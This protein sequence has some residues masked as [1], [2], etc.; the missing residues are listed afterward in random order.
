MT[1]NSMRCMKYILIVLAL[2]GC[3][4]DDAYEIP[5]DAAYEARYSPSEDVQIVGVLIPCHPFLAEY[6]R[7]VIMRLRGRTHRCDLGV[8]PGGSP[9]MCLYRQGGD[10]IVVSDMCKWYKVDMR[11][12]R[13]TEEQR[14]W[15]DVSP[16]EYLGEFN[17]VQSTWRFVGAKP[18][19]HEHPRVYKGG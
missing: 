1:L 10:Y 4:G 7:V 11:T 3:S 9:G 12:G 14:E 17:F 19:Q 5:E 15:E 16:K 18:G 2:C 8:D 13:M 6:E